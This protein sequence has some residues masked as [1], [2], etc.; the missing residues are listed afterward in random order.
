MRRSYPRLVFLISLKLKWAWIQKQRQPWNT[1]ELTSVWGGWMIQISHYCESNGART[2]SI[3]VPL[4]ESLHAENI[5]L[6]CPRTFP[7]PSI[8]GYNRFWALNYTSGCSPHFLARYLID[9][10][11]VLNPCDGQGCRKWLDGLE[12]LP[13]KLSSHLSFE[14]NKLYLVHSAI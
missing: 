6:P 2:P 3:T 8:R 9:R 14:K 5:N 11:V 13:D 7:N 12:N 4:F 10:K 1:P